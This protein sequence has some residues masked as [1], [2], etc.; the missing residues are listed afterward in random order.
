MFSP[1]P[2]NVF[3]VFQ[4]R[5]RQSSAVNKHHT[6]D[7][8]IFC[9]RKGASGLLQLMYTGPALRWCFNHYNFVGLSDYYS[10]A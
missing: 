9:L 4:S 10:E 6:Q 7:S 8:T 1:D 2:E 3:Q 5:K